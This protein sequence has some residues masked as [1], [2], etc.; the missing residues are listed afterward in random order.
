MFIRIIV[1]HLLKQKQIIM[2]REIK[3]RG[4]RSD[5]KEWVYGYYQFT[6]YSEAYKRDL[7][8][9][10]DNAHHIYPAH[11]DSSPK[12]VIPDTVGQFTGLK[13]KNGLDIYEGDILDSSEKVPMIFEVYYEDGG[14]KY[15]KRDRSVDIGFSGHRWLQNILSR[16]HV[17][18]NIHQNPEL[19]NNKS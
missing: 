5:N 15:G 10:Q 17:I 4:I 9:N 3:F 2:S 6:I 18:G 1:V 19:L 11:I 8:L 14:F 13:D 16:F 12:E 7:N